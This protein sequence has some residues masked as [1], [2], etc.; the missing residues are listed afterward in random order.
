MKISFHFKSMFRYVLT[1]FTVAMI[2]SMTASSLVAQEKDDYF[3]ETKAITFFAFDNVSIPFIQ[4][5]KVEMRTPKKYS[6]NPVLDRG[7][8]GAPDSWGVQFYG[9]VIR[10]N[11]KFRMWYAA[12][13][14]KPNSPNVPRWRGAYAE[15]NDGI[16][17]TKPNLGLVEYN[18]NT[19]NN[20]VKIDPPQLS[21]LNLKVLFDPEDPNPDQRYKI[22]THA[23]MDKSRTLGTLVPFF[24]SDGLDWKVVRPITPV[25]TKVAK[26]DL[27][28]PWTHFEPSGGL[29]KWDGLY[30]ASGQNANWASR[31]YHG[32]VVRAF[33]SGDFVNWSHASSV[34]FVRSAQYDLLGAG[35]SREGEQTHE[36]LSVWNRGSVL[37]GVSGVW[38][39]AENWKDVTIDLG[40]VMSNDGILFR[41][42]AHE[43]VFIKRG[44]DGAWDQGGVLQGQGFE[45]VGDKTYIY[46]GAWDP[47]VWEKAPPRGGVGIAMLPRDR[48]GDLRVQPEAFGTGSYHIPENEAVCEFITTTV[49]VASGTTPKFYVNADGLG[50]NAALRIELLG[51]DLKPLPG[52]SG[53]DAAIIRKNGFQTP[54]VWAAGKEMN[55]FPDKVRLRVVFEGAKRENIRLSALY[56]NNV[57]T[58]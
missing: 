44:E 50:S 54:I 17:W 9:S 6:G 53:K 22:T 32:R 24:S 51:S 38:H 27:F 5:L 57:K 35:R 36:G 58:H 40:L 16:K 29:Y 33:V 37:L 28:L 1:L 4:N 3:D 21:F 30:Y 2:V 48:F 19:N 42:P 34:G 7:P 23:Y 14:N 47:R 43:Q 46:Y 15:S 18:G 31:P 11:G 12:A 55:S 49:E 45:N 39:G 26:D 56:I 20:L 25:G 13:G 10:E 52:A 8:K 41:E